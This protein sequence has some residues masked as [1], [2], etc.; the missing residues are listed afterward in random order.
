VLSLDATADI[1][2]DVETPTE[3]PEELCPGFNGEPCAYFRFVQVKYSPG[4]GY[5]SEPL[6]FM[7]KR[8]E[9]RL[10]QLAIRKQESLIKKQ[11]RIMKTHEQINTR[12]ADRLRKDLPALKSSSSNLAQLLTC[13]TALLAQFNIHSKLPTPAH[14]ASTTNA[15]VTMNDVEADAARLQQEHNRVRDEI[16]AMKIA[17]LGQQQQI[18]QQQ[19]ILQHQHQQLQQQ[20][21]QHQQLQ[22]RQLNH[23]LST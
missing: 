6:C 8:D 4:L 13:N 14:P 11:C 7:C 2:D 12:L 3:K 1:I 22:Q 23:P 18:E 15:D 21:L 20:Q 16:S 5:I 19:Q 17:A 9:I 10:P